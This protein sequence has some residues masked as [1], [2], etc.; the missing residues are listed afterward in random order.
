MYLVDNGE[1]KGREK[2]RLLDERKTGSPPCSIMFEVCHR[3]GVND[4]RTQKEA[5]LGFVR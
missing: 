5:E 1:G 3:Q 4:N 2:F